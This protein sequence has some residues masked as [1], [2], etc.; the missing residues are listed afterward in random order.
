[1]LLASLFDGV[2]FKVYNIVIVIT[3]FIDVFQY[4]LINKQAT[5]YA[6]RS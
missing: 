4:L 5:Q 6:I 1:M 2:L 3:I